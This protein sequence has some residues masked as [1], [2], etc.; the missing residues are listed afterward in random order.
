MNYVGSTELL[1]DFFKEHR[2]FAVHLLEKMINNLLLN[3]GVVHILNNDTR[4]IH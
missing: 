4:R 3:K 2:D 1:P